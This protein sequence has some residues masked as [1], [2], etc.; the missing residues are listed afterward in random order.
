LIPNKLLESAFRRWWLLLLPIIAVPLLV[1]ALTAKSPVYASAATIWISRP[2]GIDAGA[3]S[4][5]ASPYLTPA[6]TEAQVF[7][8]LMQSESFRNAVAARVPE[9]GAESGDVVAKDVTV[10]ALG[11]NLVGILAKSASPAIA[12]GLANGI[13]AE[14]AARSAAANQLQSSSLVT[15]YQEQ[16]TPAQAELAKRQTALTN[17]LQGSTKTADQRAADP[18][19]L[20]LSQSVDTQN[21]LVSGI[22]QS[23]QTAQLGAASA[24]NS[25]AALFNV[26]DQPKL[27]DSSVKTAL[28]K[29]IGY[30]FAGLVLGLIISAAYVYASYRADH[31]LRSSQDLVGLQLPGL[32]FVPELTAPGRGPMGVV[33]NWTHFRGRRDFA[34]RVAASISTAE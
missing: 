31:T 3:L 25:Q 23:L 28:T 33:P 34:R 15:Y 30:P 4:S 11:T 19:Y 5:S 18:Q 17:Y 16:L 1:M 27:P 6:Q 29:R 32:G 14:Y 26:M 13:I 7:N 24:P 10:S 22:T 20:Q 2:P 9:L 8:D 21:T 12:Q